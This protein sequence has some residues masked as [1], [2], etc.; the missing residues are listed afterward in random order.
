[1]R[2]VVVWRS[3]VRGIDAG[4]AAAAWLSDWLAREVRLVRFD[5]SVTR[6]CNPDYAVDSGAHT[7][8]A[9]GYPVLVANMSSL[10]DLNDRLAQR[11]HAPLPMNRFRPNVV[12]DDLP[13]F[14]EDHIDPI[15]IGDLVLRVVKPCTRC[16]VT[17]TNQ[18]TAKV[19]IEPLR[20]LGEYR[21]DT[22]LDGVT[23]ATNAIVVHGGKVSKGDRVAVEY[24]F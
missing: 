10:A 23:F 15:A 5:R 4:D 12:L 2:D 17:T 18:D 11:G 21:M 24:R 16:Q 22:R 7:M 9:D 3:D 20:T 19:G 6:L 14:A 13:A 8:F 1:S